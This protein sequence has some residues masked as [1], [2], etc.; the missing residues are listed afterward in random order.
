MEA[1]LLSKSVLPVIIAGPFGTGKTFLL[2]QA[3]EYLVN[4]SKHCHILICTLT[5]S[6]ANVY[7]EHFHKRIPS[8]HDC[9]I[10]R[11]VYKG[12]MVARVPRH[13]YKYCI[14][15]S[16]SHQRFCYPSESDARKYHIIIT[17]VGM[18]QELLKLNM[19]GHFTHIFIDEAAQMTIPEGM[20]ALSLASNT[21]KVVLAG[22]H[23]ASELIIRYYVCKNLQMNIC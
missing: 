1:I 5:N 11:L 13:L 3:A 17:E 2:A 18:A 7:L 20:M 8:D 23:N 10:L 16:L 22:D 14:F 9:K 12:Q 4:Y 21:T 6:A 15:E 19:T